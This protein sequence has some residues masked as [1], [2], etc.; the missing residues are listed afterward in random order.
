MKT[1]SYISCGLVFRVGV[2]FFKK[3]FRVVGID[4][5]SRKLFFGKDGI[6]LESKIS[7]LRNKN[8]IITA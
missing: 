2:F 4:N 1:T 6:F 8:I 3:G 7:F 5:N